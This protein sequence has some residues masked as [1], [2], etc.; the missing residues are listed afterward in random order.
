MK[1]LFRYL[2]KNHA[3]A[4]FLL[5]EVFSLSMVFNYNSFQRSQ[6]LNSANRVSGTVYNTYQQIT[7]YFGLIKVNR[8]LAE[9]NARL[10]ALMQKYSDKLAKPDILTDTVIGPEALIRFIPATVINN[11]VNRPFNYITLNKGSN[12]GIQPDQGIISTQGIVGVV[13]QVSPSYSMALSVLNQR[14][15]I[16]ARLSKT[17]F[18]GSLVWQG[19][20]YRFAH[21]TEIPLHVPIEIGD[22]VVTS[23]YSTI[24]P[25][26]ILIGIIHDFT[27][28]DG[29]NYYDIEVRLAV[30]FKSITHVEVIENLDKEEM[31]K[32][33]EMLKDD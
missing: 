8:D 4:L 6:Y 10:H 21:L 3:L 31:D 5:L 26:K 2:L 19:N 16:S 33:K 13:A 29:E 9:E 24:F 22:T 23:G 1:S 18:F 12:D 7:R 20:D 11:S 14:W 32:L 28:P 25:E 15:S 30:D 17:G 27:R